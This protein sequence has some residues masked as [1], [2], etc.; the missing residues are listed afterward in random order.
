MAAAARAAERPRR[1]GSDANDLDTAGLLD[2]RSQRMPPHRRRLT[3]S[4]ARAVQGQRGGGA[5]R[6]PRRRGPDADA[7]GRA[8]RRARRRRVA[9]GRAW[10]RGLLAAGRAQQRRRDHAVAVAVAIAASVA[11]VADELPQLQPAGSLRQEVP[12][13]WC[14]AVSVGERERERRE[15]ERRSAAQSTALAGAPPVPAAHAAD[16]GL[17]RRG[18]AGVRRERER[19]RE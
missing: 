3:A 2:T 11:A 8:R 7:S 15:G 13:D 5:A 18:A 10:P 1:L 12:V 19:E 17:A 14:G 9:D 16:F 6:G 4:S